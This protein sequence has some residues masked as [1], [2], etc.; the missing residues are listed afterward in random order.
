MKKANPKEN[1]IDLS[2]LFK[3]DSMHLF[4]M[5][6]GYFL[7]ILVL[8]SI[9]QIIRVVNLNFINILSMITPISLYLIIGGE[10]SW[11][12]K[13]IIISIFAIIVLVVP[14]MFT[15][16]YDLT[17]D[18][19]TYH[20]SAIAFIKNGWNPLYETAR[21][22]QENNQEV[23]QIPEDS[24]IDLWMEHYPK[25]TWIIA[26]VIYEYTGNI[27]SGK[28]ITIILNIMLLI[29]LYNCLIKILDK[30][31]VY[32]LCLLTALN[33]ILLVQWYSY[34]VDGLMGILFAIEILLLMN[35]KPKEKMNKIEWMCLAS[36]ASIMVNIKFTGLLCSGVIAAVY[37]FYWLIKNR[38][39]KD[40][41]T[42][43][44]RVTIA[45]SIVYI[46]AIFL[47]GANSYTIDHHM[48]LYPLMG[49]NKVDIITTMQPK[50][51]TNKTKIEKFVISLFSKTENVTYD[52]NPTLKFPLRV[53]R[54]ELEVNEIPDIRIGGFGPLFA[55]VM[56]ITIVLLG[57]GLYKLYKNDK[58][59][60]IIFA[61]PIISILISMILVGESWWARYIPQFY[62]LPLMSIILL[63]YEKD[64]FKKNLM[65]ILLSGIL[66]IA[67]VLNASGFLWGNLKMLK[68]FHS[69]NRDIKEMKQMK[70][71]HLSIAQGECYGFYYTLKDSHVNFEIDDAIPENQT[72][73]KY[74][75]RVK[76]KTN[77]ELSKT[78]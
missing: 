53:Y 30:K 66:V 45:F 35:I 71:L 36:I 17:I 31:W 62:I 78:N 14:F 51:F 55:M 34:Y 16:T 24:R 46:I 13:T 44:K 2:D 57:I 42:I 73:F 39:E 15:K 65:P 33:P 20:K 26:A 76:V 75:W 1:K 37:Y 67:I 48:P 5:L 10:K 7:M 11:K 25:A 68:S 41:M 43:L 38:K 69:I 77:E 56:M 59:K 40:F 50:S 54:S 8:Y 52:N 12:T 9:F 6:C 27:E 4:T 3:N 58:N 21:E 19:N 63:L 70:N 47:V 64:H 74:S 72:I 32:L 60:L 29:I 18:G 61:L 28:C 22:F 49:K 23:I